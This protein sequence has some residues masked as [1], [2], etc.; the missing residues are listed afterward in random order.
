MKHLAG[1]AKGVRLTGISKGP[2]TV[3]CESCGTSKAQRIIRREE[4]TP[5]HGPGE[6]LAIDFHDFAESTMHGEKTL[7]LITD[8]FSGF[9]WDYYMT[10]H[11][12]DEILETLKWF[13]DY[14]EKAYVI[15][16]VKIEMDNEIAKRLEVKYY[17]EYKKRIIL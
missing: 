14:L 5:P 4:R 12:G 8:R 17:L 1:A 3:E 15:S 16:P 11:R 2:T 10:S 13:L 9:M 6:H 7:M